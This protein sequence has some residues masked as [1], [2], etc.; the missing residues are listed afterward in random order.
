M[1][2]ED[3]KAALA[4]AIQ[5]WNAGRYEEYLQFYAP[6]VILHGFAP[7]LPPGRE[8]AKAFYST[9]W[10]A[11]P[12]AQ[13][14][15]DTVVAEGDMLACRFSMAGTQQE[16]FMGAPPPDKPLHVQGQTM[17][18]F[19][20]GQCVERWNQVDMLGWLQQLGVIALPA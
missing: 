7:G 10:A 2:A 3:N 20:G 18:R 5:H 19:A 14:T 16:V 8:G 11:Y 1:P 17:M 12:N 9:V 13:L 15:I 6:D 4:E